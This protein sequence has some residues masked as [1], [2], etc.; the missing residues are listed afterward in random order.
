MTLCLLRSVIKLYSV[1]KSDTTKWVHINRVRST[2]GIIGRRDGYSRRIDG[3]SFC[4]KARTVP[5]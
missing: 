5:G 3:V 2:E 1:I 4:R